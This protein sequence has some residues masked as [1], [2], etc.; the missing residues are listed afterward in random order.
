GPEAFIQ[1]NVAGTFQLLEAVRAY[2]NTLAGEARD[3]FRYLQV[4][5]D[6][7]YGS[8]APGAPAFAEG[9]PYR[10]NNPYS[11]SKAAADHLVRAYG[12][13]YGLPVLTTHCPNNHGPRQFPE[14]LIPLL[15]HR[16]LAGQPLPP[17]GGGAD[18]RDGPYVD[19]PR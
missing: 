4:S 14:K 9:D 6:E 3:A 15:V 16:A 19:D 5:T 8:L 11:A 10:P 12:H 7:V 2:W 17:D 13:T 1:T 18:D